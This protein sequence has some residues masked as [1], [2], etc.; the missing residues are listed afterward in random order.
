M[1]SGRARTFHP[2]NA[3]MECLNPD[4]FDQ[5]AKFAWVV[6]GISRNNGFQVIPAISIGIVYVSRLS[7]CLE[8]GPPV[9]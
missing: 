8:P 9:D 7:H 4:D 5:I 3:Y 2:I 6:L 1:I